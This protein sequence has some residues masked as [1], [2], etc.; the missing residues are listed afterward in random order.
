MKRKK[1]KER[2]FSFFSEKESYLSFFERKKTVF[3]FLSF[4]WKRKK[5]F[6]SFSLPKKLSFLSFLLDNSKKF[7]FLFLSQMGKFFFFPERKFFVLPIPGWNSS[8]VRSPTAINC[9]LAT[10]GEELV[11]HFNW[12]FKVR[13]NSLKRGFFIVQKP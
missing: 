5:T 6:F 11:E 12:V 8:L 3:F 2:K 10:S 7:F 9:G 4:I 1:K 13:L